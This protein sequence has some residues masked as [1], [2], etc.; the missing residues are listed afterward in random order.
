MIVL[1]IDEQTGW[2]GGEQQAS[3]LIRGLAE[4]GH[5]C[6][7][8]GRVGSEFLGSAHGVPDLTRIGVSCRGEADVFTAMRLAKVVKSQGVD[9]LHAHTSHA[10]TYACLARAI[11]RRG[12]VVASRRVDFP[13]NRNAFSRWK[14]RQADRVIAISDRIAEV[15]REFG[16]GEDCLRTVHSGIDVERF[17]VPPL[18]RDELGVPEDAFLLGN[19]AALVDHKDQAT[20]LDAMH[21]VVRDTPN[22][23]LLI[24]G[25]GPLREGLLKQAKSL[26][27]EWNVHFLG[28]RKDVPRILRTLDLF[29]MSSKEEG[30]GTSVLDAMACDVPVVATAGGGIPEMVRHHETGRL[31]PIQNPRELASCILQAIRNPNQSAVMAARA[32]TM[33]TEKFTKER[34]IEGNLRVYEELVTS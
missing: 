14:Y 2:R 34:M 8:A 9:I 3:Y 10:I 1:H 27:L 20:L 24:A 22:A 21:L 31:A 18:T 6:L 17:D 16:I 30:L 19:V 26:D 7:I 25:D 5:R 12:K 32:K 23:H 15:M 13:P 33:L 11:A 29:V 4:R 28:Y